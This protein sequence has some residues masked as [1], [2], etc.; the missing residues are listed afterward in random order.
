M[1]PVEAPLEKDGT[2]LMSTLQAAVPGAH[3]LYFCENG[4]KI[5]LR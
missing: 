1:E 5:A 3:G 4:K 2:L